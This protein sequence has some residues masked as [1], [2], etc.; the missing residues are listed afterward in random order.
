SA[1]RS[2]HVARP[3]LRAGSPARGA[4]APRRRSWAR[5]PRP[6][7]RPL[8]PEHAAADPSRAA[9][10]LNALLRRAVELGASDIHLKTGQ[11]PVVRCD[12]ALA[13]L[14]EWPP[15]D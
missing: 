3:R 9:M 13:R 14:K 2:A 7:A 6:G 10:H 15:L 4:R 12:G 5:V 1:Q 11:P 8:K